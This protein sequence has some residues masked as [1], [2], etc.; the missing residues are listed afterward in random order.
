VFRLN[1]KE[2]R[3]IDDALAALEKQARKMGGSA[4][5]CLGSRFVH[6]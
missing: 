3:M 6:Y 2:E 4:L 5:R 1:A